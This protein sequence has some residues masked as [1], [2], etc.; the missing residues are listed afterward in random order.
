MQISR[1]KLISALCIAFIAGMTTYGAIKYINRNQVTTEP[2]ETHIITSE[3]IADKTTVARMVEGSTERQSTIVVGKGDTLISVLVTTIGLTRDHAHRAVNALGKVYNPKALRVGQEIHIVYKPVSELKEAE[4]L[5]I[6]F[7]TSAGNDIVLKYNG[8]EFIAE[9]FE[10]QLTRVQRKV[11]G[12]INSS[13]YSAALKQGVPATIVKE[14]ISALS[15]DINWQH[16]PKTGDEF[17]LLYDVFVDSAG[18]V[19]KNGTLKYAGFSP[20]G[21]WR[22]IY[23]FQSSN[24]GEGYYN[25][26]GESVIKSLLQTPLDP[27]KMRVTSKFGMRHHK[28]LGY[29][30]M[31]T[32]VDFGAPIG[33]PVMA[34]GDGVVI[35][36]GWNGA[37]GNYILVRHNAEYATAYAHLSKIN[38]KVGK[39]VRQREVMGAV[40]TT[41]RSTGPHLHYEV[42][43]RGRHVNPQSIKQLPT[44]KLTGKDLNKFQLIKR[45]FD[46]Q[47]VTDETIQLA[48]KKVPL[49][50]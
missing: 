26:K 20:Q 50:S 18:C 42:L 3:Q 33:T 11:Q 30:K 35:K 37:Y 45:E 2:E 21:N 39:R 9:K 38:V 4:L 31:H 7:K 32:G 27:T 24:G 22:K 28:M 36:A 12:K 15:Y 17:E 49:T 19:I 8:T 44:S 41:G 29:T 13:F 10:V 6:N 40:G 34:A 1:N 5:S 23:A 43:Y 14:A 46:K 25:A 48:A 47:V 16:D